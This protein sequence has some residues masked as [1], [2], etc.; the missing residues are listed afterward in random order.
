MLIMLN[1]QS[2]ESLYVLQME[3]SGHLRP[4]LISPTQIGRAGN[5]ALL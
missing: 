3:F 2:Q 4:L 1:V 5:V